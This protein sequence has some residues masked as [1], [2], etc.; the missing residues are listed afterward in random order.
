MNSTTA[1]AAITR[2]VTQRDQGLGAG[3]GVPGPWGRSGRV[4]GRSGGWVLTAE[5]CSS[6]VAALGDEV[7]LGDPRGRDGRSCGPDTMLRLGP[8]PPR[9]EATTSRPSRPVPRVTVG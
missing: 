3:P 9:S 1:I 4:G 5:G 8:T 2:N 7:G 6:V